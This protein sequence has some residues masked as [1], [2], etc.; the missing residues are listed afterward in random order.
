MVKK[1]VKTKGSEPTTPATVALAK[2]G[3]AFTVHSYEHD[4]RAV[5]AGASYAGEAA[6][7]MGIDPGRVYKTLVAEADSAGPRGG[8][9]LAIAVVPASG[10]L[11]LKALAMALGGRHATM[12]DPAEA[13]RATGYVVGG[14]SPVGQR[15]ALPTVVDESALAWPTVF[16][17]AG[18]RGV[19]VELAASDLVTATG[20]RVAAIARA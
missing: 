6:D 20:A 2:A 10:H 12:A 1:A 14:I 18:R 4:A 16:V 15:R 17:S 11:D 7:A 9:G 19:E 13:E 3:I 8:T 5:A